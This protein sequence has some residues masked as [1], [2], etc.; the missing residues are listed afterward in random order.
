MKVALLQCPAWGRDCPPYTVALLSAILR[1]KGHKAFG[2]D[3][4]NALY[5]TSSEKY[6]KMWDDK[7]NYSFW[8]N[9]SLIGQLIE[10][11]NRMIDL[12]IDKILET[13]AKIIGFTV[14]FSSRPFSLEIARKIKKADKSRIIVFG[15]PDCTGELRGIASIREECV[16]IVVVGEGDET[17]LDL[18]QMVEEKGEVDFCQGVYLKKNG[19]PFYCGDRQPVRYLDSLPFPD[20]SDFKKDILLGH[21]RQPARLDILD[22]RGCITGCHF[23]SE[24]QFWK[25]FRTMS[26]KRM[27]EEVAYQMQRFP[28]VNYFYFIGSLLN[29]NMRELTNF[30]DQVISSGLKIR[31]SGQAVIRPEMTREMMEKM[32]KAGCEWLGYGIESGSQRVIKNMNK[33]FSIAN[34][35][36]VLENTKRAGIST[37]ANFMFGIP[38]ETRE[39]FQ[40]TLEFLVR[41]R[42]NMDSI[43]ASQSFCVIDQGTYL[44]T[45]AKE[46]GIKN[47]DH[48]LYWETQGNDYLER[49]R[50][51]EEFCRLAL[52]LGIPETSGVLR[53]KPDKWVL[54]GDYFYFKK[55]YFSALECY[56]KSIKCE[57]NNLTTV[58]KINDCRKMLKGKK[59]R[60]TLSREVRK[61]SKREK[62]SFPIMLPE[63]FT[64]EEPVLTPEQEK[65]KGALLKLGLSEKL[66]NYLLIEK[67]KS[68]R[69][70]YVSGY[71]YWLTIDPANFCNLSCPFCPTGQKRGS[72]EKGTMAFDNFKKIADELGRYLIHIDFCNWGEPFL[73]PQL[74]ELIKYAKQYHIDTKVDSNLN[75][76][77]EKTAEDIILSGL[78][79]IIVS[80]DGASRQTYSQY[81][82]NGD[83]DT[84]IN[85]LKLLIKKKA[86]LGRSN[87]YICWQFLVFR[88]NEHEIEEVKKMG[89]DLGVD[90]VSITKAFI[91]N[92]DWFP[93]NEEYSNYRKSADKKK[94]TSEY[95]KQAAQRF[96]NWPWEEI[97]VNPNGSVSVCCSVEDEKNDF[98]NIFQQP[99]KEIWNNAAYQQARRFIKYK[100]APDDA[101]QSICIGCKHAGMINIDILSCH[102]LFACPA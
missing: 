97:A 50:R 46:L 27:F 30:C 19:K 42:Q 81:R 8:S 90:S 1:L 53:N 99:F 84:A 96:C 82:V 73:N 54:F 55:N 91:G 88:H 31:W 77:G 29:G 15:G 2:F 83:F 87:P 6:R 67:E 33:H 59:I 13:E 32:K 39:D 93:R 49:F 14:H 7:D 78:D 23:C 63:E 71:P 57:S 47:S 76:F 17:I 20:Y 70:E 101:A 98:G 28:G 11:N 65:V 18:A 52:A 79:K 21:Y 26:G 40:K 12:M 25:Y 64:G 10:E 4:N 75:H 100:S 94:F 24:W 38:T 16:D 60:K 37:Q 62:I 102:S 95:F 85:N 80:I 56:E 51:Y 89:R 92:K 61:I 69:K 86:Q 66:D 5:W 58:T 9:P 41:N 34:A 3:F 44:Y 35:E 22:S 43:L 36:A 45:H 74:P 72:R 48:H 68:Q